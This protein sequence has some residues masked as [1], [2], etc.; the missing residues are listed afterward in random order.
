M[1]FNLLCHLP[2]GLFH[3]LMFLYLLRILLNTDLGLFF[4]QPLNATQCVFE[5]LCLFIDNCKY[6]STS[7]PYKAAFEWFARSHILRDLEEG[8]LKSL[9]KIC[10]EGFLPSRKIGNMA[11]PIS[12]RTNLKEE[13][14]RS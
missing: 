14:I 10:F 5:R 12:S 6:L 9:C 3:V 13:R 8:Q 2:R 1:S 11:K 4:K 7:L